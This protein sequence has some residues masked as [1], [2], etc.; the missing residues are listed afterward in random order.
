MKSFFI[1]ESLNT[2]AIENYKTSA[3]IND[4]AGILCLSKKDYLDFYGFFF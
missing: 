4:S 2:F 1:D 3:F